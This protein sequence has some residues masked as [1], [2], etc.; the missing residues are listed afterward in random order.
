MEI[1]GD[2]NVIKVIVHILDR[3]K[4][5]QQLSD[6]DLDINDQLSQLIIKYIKK[7]TIHDSR[8]FAKF[9][10]G[11]MI[12]SSCQ[13]ILHD[14]N[15][16]IEESKKISRQLFLAMQ[17]TNA[18]SA[19]LL[20]VYY[21]INAEKA[22]AILKLDFDENFRTVERKKGYKTKIDVQVDSAGFNRRQRIQK[23]VFVYEEIIIEESSPIIVLDKQRGNSNI[24]YYF[25]NKFLEC[26]LINDDTENTKNIINEINDFIN[27]KYS[28]D[29][30]MKLKKRSA[31]T[32]FFEENDEFQ[33]EDM[34]NKLFNNNNTKIELK[35]KLANKN[36]DFIFRIDKL[37]AN[38]LLKDIEVTTE[39][40][41][42]IRGNS[43]FFDD[44][45]IKINNKDE[46]YADILIQNVKLIEK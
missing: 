16:F 34:L 31:L 11:S 38:K 44:E 25:S 46:G 42:K 45:T 18:P 3:S 14:S 24:S 43:S 10:D 21:E 40:G 12:L 7:S 41:I 22:I 26:E 23:C 5:R 1:K 17:G 6:F 8:R 33:L 4:T 28:D 19:N 15:N 37:R 29:A 36:I 35:N 20:I 32:N 30:N 27:E 2:I 13:K 39:N 9:N